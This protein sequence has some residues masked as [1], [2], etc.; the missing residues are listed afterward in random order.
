MTDAQIEAR[1][2]QDNAHITAIVRRYGW[3]IQ[4][5]CG[6][7]LKESG[8]AGPP[9]AYTVGLFGLHH[10]ELLILGVPPEVAAGVLNMLGDRIKAGEDLTPN[11]PV[12]FED[13]AWKLLPEV[14]P[15]PGEVL[16][17]ANSYYDLPSCTSVPALQLSYD[18][19]EGRFPWEP[20]Y[21][22]PSMQPRPGTFDGHCGG[23]RA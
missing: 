14:V 16:F 22:A 13:R 11:F 5:V 18:D 10:P 6:S 23:S 8:E 15:N 3:Y 1:I 7:T 9:F 2:D 12:S 19:R 4:Y 21:A 20:R 17:V